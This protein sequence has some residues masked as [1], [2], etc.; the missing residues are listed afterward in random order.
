MTIS[1]ASAGLPGGQVVIGPCTT[2][3]NATIGEKLFVSLSSGD[4]TTAVPAGAT[5]VAVFLPQGTTATVKFRTNL[6][7]GDGGVLIAPVTINPW[8]K[9]DVVT[10]ETSVVL[11]S[12]GSVPGVEIDF[13]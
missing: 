13:I 9:K 1:G 6:D 3:A 7:S 11:N 12:T 4:N 5:C 10:G 8:F 2:T